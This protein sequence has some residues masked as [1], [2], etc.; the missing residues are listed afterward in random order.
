MIKFQLLFCNSKF[1]QKEEIFEYN[2]DI[3]E[4]YG[5]KIATNYSL[6]L[7]DIFKSNEIAE[8]VINLF[9]ENNIDYC[10]SAKE[11]YPYHFT[12]FLCFDGGVSATLARLGGLCQSVNL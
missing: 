9:N 1:F 3:G 12:I 5:I 6:I 10:V 11:V 7:N 2:F 8:H 4:C